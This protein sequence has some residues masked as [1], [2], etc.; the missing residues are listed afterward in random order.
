MFAEN[1]Q[2]LKKELQSSGQYFENHVLILN[3]SFTSPKNDDDCDYFPSKFDPYL[4][5]LTGIFYTDIWVVL[6]LDT[7]KLTAFYPKP[8]ETELCFIKYYEQPELAKFGVTKVIM[9]EDLVQYLNDQQVATV[10]FIKGRSNWPRPNRSRQ[11]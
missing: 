5:W 8:T 6:H 10:H 7:L 2:R 11:R 1:R 3:K 4:T 9:E